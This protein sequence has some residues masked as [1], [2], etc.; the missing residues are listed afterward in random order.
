MPSDRARNLMRLLFLFQT[1]SFEKST[2]YLDLINEAA[3]RGHKVTV[4]AGTENRDAPAGRIKNGEVEVV[5]LKLKNQF[6]AGKIKKGIIQLSIAP[7]MTGLIKKELWKEEFDI[8]TYPTPPIT[9]APVVEKCRRH[10]KCTTYLMLKDIFPQNAIDLGMMSKDGMT[11]KYFKQLEKRLYEASD[12]IG[13]M[14][15][16]NIRYLLSHEPYIDERKVE[17]FPNTVKIRESVDKNK[18]GDDGITLFFGGNMGKPQA[19]EFLL[20][21]IKK[22]SETEELKC[23]S[24]F[25]IGDGSESSLIEEFIESKKPVNLTYEHFLPRSEYEE[26][27][28]NADVGI[29]SLSDKFTIPNYPSR[30]LSY[31]QTATPVFAVTDENTDIK[32]L[33]IKEAHCG[34]WTRSG[35]IDGFINTLKSMVRMKDELP[36]LGK[37]GRKYLEENFDVTR[38]IEILEKALRG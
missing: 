20:E 34:F 10:F 16:A 26:K 28:K 6:G 12:K 4:I 15:Q 19:V 17:Y 11:A 2:I 35:D 8:I 27:L 24:F 29:V 9:L 23:V 32:E 18:K 22:A 1:F 3:A 21:G 38:S 37:N 31:M 5:W 7:L 13:C 33:V 25:F 30:V 14:S 36:E